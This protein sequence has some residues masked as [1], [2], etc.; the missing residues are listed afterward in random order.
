[1]ESLLVPS[2]YKFPTNKLLGSLKGA[3]VRLLGIDDHFYQW[4]NAF[5][6]LKAS[7]LLLRVYAY[8]NSY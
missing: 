2:N 1:M 6:S 3:K 8:L 7:N 4:T 5:F